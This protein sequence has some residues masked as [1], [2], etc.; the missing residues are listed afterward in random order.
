M[1]WFGPEA[2]FVQTSNC[3]MLH[4]KAG[5]REDRVQEIHGS[6]GRLQCSAPC[7]DDLHR[8]DAAFLERLRAEPGWVPPCPKCKACLRPNVMIFNDGR[9]VDAHLQTQRD[10]MERFGE[11][12]RVAR[13]R[14]PPPQASSSSQR[15]RVSP[16]MTTSQNWVVLEIGAGVVVPSIRVHGETFG[17]QGAGLVRINPSSHECAQME[18]GGGEGFVGLKYVPICARS[19]CALAEL[20]KQLDQPA[21]AKLTS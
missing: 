6:L 11:R 14:A 12:F 20:V 21:A 19:D 1:A 16:T 13:T 9:L 4:E 10:N 5:V 8:V 7:C 15:G 17:A 3:D 18:T 2:C